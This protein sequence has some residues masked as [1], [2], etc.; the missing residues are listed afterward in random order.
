LRIIPLEPS[1]SSARRFASFPPFAEAHYNLGCACFK[2]C[3]AGDAVAAFREA[4][5]YS[6][7]EDGLDK[8][9]RD[10]IGQLEEILIRGTTFRTIDAYIENEKLFD[11]AFEHLRNQQYSPAAEVFTK[12]LKQN[13]RH[14][15]SHG[16]LGLCYAGLGRKAAA[17]E[18]LDRAL[19]LDS[20]YEPAR[21]NK[22]LIELMTEGEPFVP[23]AMAETEYYRER[24]KSEATNRPRATL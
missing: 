20:S 7:G 11:L 4:I 24:L 19:Q 18:S 10:K 8:M 17:L 23:E 21:G 15:Q 3:R 9:A 1:L 12:V 13:P 5:R 22:R 16:N 2:S 6:N 14:V